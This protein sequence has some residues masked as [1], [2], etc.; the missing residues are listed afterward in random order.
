MEGYNP[1]RQCAHLVRSHEMEQGG[2]SPPQQRVL[3]TRSQGIEGDTPTRQQAPPA[4]R[5]GT[6][7]GGEHPEQ[8]CA[9]P[10]QGLQ[11][12]QGGGPPGQEGQ[13]RAPPK[14][15]HALLVHGF[16]I[17][18]V[19]T[20]LPRGG[21]GG[22]P[23]SAMRNPCAKPARGEGRGNPQSSEASHYKAKWERGGKQRTEDKTGKRKRRTA[24]SRGEG[25]TRRA[26]SIHSG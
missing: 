16:R 23:L 2:G 20:P 8:Q 10:A 21:E 25:D 17:W 9:L 22:D 19:E 15:Q 12:R 3:P 14:Q 24:P 1:T 18:R 13:K 11:E 4:C 26:G 7:E 6:E 5:Q